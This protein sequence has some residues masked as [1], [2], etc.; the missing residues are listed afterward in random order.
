MRQYGQNA[1]SAGP[2]QTIR[3]PAGGWIV[4]GCSYPTTIKELQC[5][6]SIMNLRCAA[7]LAWHLQAGSHLMKSFVVFG[8]VARL[9]L[10][11]A[12]V[13][14]F[15]ACAQSQCF[16]CVRQGATGLANGSDW[17]NAF[18][19]L[20]ATLQRGATYYLAGGSYPSVQS[21]TPAN[22]GISRV[23]KLGQGIPWR[24]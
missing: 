11:A 16:Y 21:D 15:P 8:S 13:V 19:S 17:T 1:R 4:E 9:A 24:R 18:T 14:S 2:A 23:L 5:L 22:S 3:P 7:A 6:D 10:L 12:G 20:P